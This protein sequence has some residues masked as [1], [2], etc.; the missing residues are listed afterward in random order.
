MEIIGKIFLYKELIKYPVYI[1]EILFLNVH[2]SKYNNT[3][4]IAQYKLYLFL[5]ITERIK[6]DNA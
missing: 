1:F 5:C 2:K 4:R 6:N 3:L